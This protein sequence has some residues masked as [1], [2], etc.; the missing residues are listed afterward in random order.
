MPCGQVLEAMSCGPLSRW[1]LFFII[2]Q[3]LEIRK[4][5]TQTPLFFVNYNKNL[6]KQAYVNLY[7]K[8]NCLST[9]LLSFNHFV[10]DFSKY[11]Y[12]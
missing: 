2:V 3:L 1:V 4:G 12:I 6:C 11:Y 5:K 8:G 10:L 7:L 9:L